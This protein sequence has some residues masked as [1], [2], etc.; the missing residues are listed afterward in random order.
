[1][2]VYYSKV[3]FLFYKFAKNYQLVYY[4][5]FNKKKVLVTGGT[6]MTGAY[7]LAKLLQKNYEVKALKRENSNTNIT[8]NIFNFLFENSD[9][10]FSKINW[11][12]GDITDYNSINQA[13]NSVDYVYHLAAKVSFKPSD[14]EFILNNNVQGTANIVNA[15]L[16]YKIKKLCHVSSIA[17]L[18]NS[19]NGD[20]I[21]EETERQK[22]QI[23]SGYSLSK[24]RSENEVWRGI[25]EGLNAVIVNPSIILGVGNWEK[26]S[27]RFIKTVNDGFKYFTNGGTG[28]IDVNDV[29]DV[30]IK[31]T[32]SNISNE[33]FILNSENLSYKTFF[34]IIADNLNKKRAHIET[35]NIMLKSLMIYD[36][37]RYLTTGKEPRVTK[38]TVSSA[39]QT[40][41]YSN[42]KI[43]ETLNYDFTPIKDSLKIICERFLFELNSKK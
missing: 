22:K 3:L 25:A 31:L 1:M 5:Q 33:R 30:M 41:T 20:F 18:G 19:F 4:M 7:L 21:N 40:K 2:L 16:N 24:F 13:M 12:N 8:K 35:S 27:A 6:G 10:Q 11:I 37:L 36:K 14:K 43:K 32:E 29:V 9:E 42:E 38:F 34:E 28:F 23:V 39:L 26:G 17:T 15:A